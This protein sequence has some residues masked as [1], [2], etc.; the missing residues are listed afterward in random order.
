MIRHRN[1]GWNA[2]VLGVRTVWLQA[3]MQHRTMVTKKM[4]LQMM[5]RQHARAWMAWRRAT[6]AMREESVRRSHGAA[7]AHLNKRHKT[8][9]GRRLCTERRSISD[10][11]FGPS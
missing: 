7:V 3:D 10:R 11:F 9:V 6:V 4:L 5:H 1:R 2:G 8:Y